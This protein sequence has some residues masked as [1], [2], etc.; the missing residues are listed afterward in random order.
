MATNG[1]WLSRNPRKRGRRSHDHQWSTYE[2]RGAGLAVGPGRFAPHWALDR[3]KI[4][5]AGA[6]AG[7]SLDD[8]PPPGRTGGAADAVTAAAATTGGGRA[9]RN[10]YGGGAPSSARGGAAGGARVRVADHRGTAARVGSLPVSDGP[11]PSEPFFKG[12]GRVDDGAGGL[13]QNERFLKSLSNP[14]PL[15]AKLPPDLRSTLN[16][17]QCHVVESVLSGHSTFFTGPAGR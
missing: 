6:R 3:E 13:F 15:T 2:A 1:E 9:V 7:V 12:G 14:P 17:E 8:P 5:A 11:P 4:T 16:K 10:P